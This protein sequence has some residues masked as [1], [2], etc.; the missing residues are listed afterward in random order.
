MRLRFL[1]LITLMMFC[2]ATLAHAAVRPTDYLALGDSLA[3]GLQPS[4]S[5]DVATGQGYADDLFAQ[6]SARIPGLTLAKL[7]CSGETTASMIQGGVCSY[8]EG[9]QLDA[10]VSFLKTHQ[11][12]FITLDIG[13]NDVDSCISQTGIDSSC[14][15]NGFKSVGA[16]L[17]WILR[18][19]R[20][21]AGA[22][23]PIVAMNYYDPFLAAWALGASGQALALQSL[24]ATTDFNL[25]L[26]GIYLA[27]RVHLADV[28][29][30]F[31]IYNFLPVPGENVP[32]N[33]FVTEAW[34]W[35]AA[36]A[37]FGPDIHPNAAGY[38]VI[39]AAFASKITPN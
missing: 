1:S 12:A 18:T 15:Q 14:I 25:I 8:P 22:K 34:T 2:G 30:A 5:G 39:A 26:E 35:M 36:P 23:T 7:G 20:L 28:A 6:F 19:L 33:V 3:I 13:A 38:A 11:V 9:S 29:H 21:A 27:F 17:P 32:V 24:Q 4:P 31:R 10:A 16:N 37:P